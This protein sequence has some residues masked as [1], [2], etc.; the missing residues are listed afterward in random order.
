MD[1]FSRVRAFTGAVVALCLGSASAPG[2]ELM[3]PQS[4]PARYD[5]I[6]IH[7]SLGRVLV[8][9]NGGL[10]VYEWS[11][12]YTWMPDASSVP[13]AVGER[14]QTF[15]Y[16]VSIPRRWTGWPD[17]WRQTRPR[18]SQDL[19]PPSPGA[20]YYL[21]SISP[22]GRQV[23]F[24]ELDW[25]DGAARAG[26]V[27]VVDPLPPEDAV[28]QKITWFDVPPD[29]ARLDEPPVWVSNDE[30]VYPAGG[31]SI[32]ALAEVRSAIRCVEC[33][34]REQRSC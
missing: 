30:V 19:F 12:P 31:T 14:K 1:C 9:S 8:A 32:P 11:R 21:G 18:E 2:E 29:V 26:V 20:T 6:R 17:L 23:S 28:P 24:Y 5:D 10:V 15:L 4:R 27:L 3:F 25:D 34:C 22:D 13:R 33:E 7:Q 16:R